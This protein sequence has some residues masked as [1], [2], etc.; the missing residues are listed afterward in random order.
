MF[1]LSGRGRVWWSAGG[2]LGFWLGRRGGGSRRRGETEGGS[3]RGR[4]SDR[5]V[6]RNAAA[7]RLRP[8]EAMQ[9]GAVEASGQR[10][11]RNRDKEL[12]RFIGRHGLVRIEHL[13]AA[14]EV[15]RT[16]TY[17]RVAACVEAGLLEGVEILRSEPRLLRAT[18]DGLRYA[19]LGLPVAAVSPGSIDHMLRCTTTAVR[20]GKEIGHDRVL[21][22]RE[23]IFAEQIDGRRIASAEVEGSS[24]GR[25]RMHRADLALMTDAGTVAVEVELTPK[26]PR[27]LEGLMRAWR[28]AVGT[29]VVSEV[30][31][32]CEPGQTRRA[33]ERAIAN[34]RAERLIA[35]LEA[36]PR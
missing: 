13:M 14:M 12:V 3:A 19:G 34:V 32:L 35:V 10:V 27:R 30:R 11:A 22:E 17:R 8:M 24:S 20:A 33:V 2:S 9:G 36:P 31:Y 5:G 26:A 18:R 15:G 25:R 7:A 21:S 29:E 16:V 6:G 4:W 1:V 23:I 28:R